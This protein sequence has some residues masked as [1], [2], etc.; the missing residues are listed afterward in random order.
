MEIISQSPLNVR[1]VKLSQRDVAES[2]PTSI[3]KEAQILAFKS[4]IEASCKNMDV[5]Y[6]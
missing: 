5:G 3:S 2:F 1:F 6:V 4:F